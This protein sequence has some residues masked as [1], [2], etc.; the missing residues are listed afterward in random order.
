MKGTVG[1]EVDLNDSQ[2]TAFIPETDGAPLR[3]ISFCASLC[4]KMFSVLS[5]NKS[6]FC[7]FLCV[8]TSIK[9]K[10]WHI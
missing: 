6:L 2:F 4:P 3:G 8:M 10:H 1:R 9:A 7:F 5:L